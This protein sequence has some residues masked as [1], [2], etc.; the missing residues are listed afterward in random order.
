MLIYIAYFN[1]GPYLV[2]SIIRC[3][4]QLNFSDSH[5]HLSIITDKIQ[6]TKKKMLGRCLLLISL[7]LHL[8]AIRSVKALPFFTT[9]F[10]APTLKSFSHEEKA[11]KVAYW[12]I[13]GAISA[14]DTALSFL[15]GW[16]DVGRE[17]L[18]PVQRLKKY[19][20]SYVGV[21]IDE[22][23]ADD[24]I[25]HLPHPASEE[26]FSLIKEI[27]AEMKY[28]FANGRPSDGR[29]LDLYI[30]PHD[31]KF[32]GKKELNPIFLPD[33]HVLVEAYWRDG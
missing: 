14:F 30:T 4:F 31:F 9:L 27:T 20:R 10:T 3:E 32:Y 21:I 26:C 23:L 17:P 29:R 22:R 24:R 25:L 6:E 33:Q 1:S 2:C 15:P 19:L 18:L 8:G 28:M 11:L 7:A 16:T 13:D 12:E 5:F